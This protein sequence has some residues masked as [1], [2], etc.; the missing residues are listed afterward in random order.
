MK[1]DKSSRNGSKYTTSKARIAISMMDEGES[2]ALVAKAVGVT[3][4]TLY[5]WA[6]KYKMFG[7]EF[8]RVQKI[9]S[10][11]RGVFFRVMRRRR[12]TTIQ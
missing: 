4:V 5:R 7:K 8:R 2:L 1:K 12:E 10:R 9:R 11:H 3:R 6:K